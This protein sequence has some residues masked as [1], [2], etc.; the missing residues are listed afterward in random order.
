MDTYAVILCVRYCRDVVD[1][2]Q[3]SGPAHLD[4]FAVQLDSED[5]A[6]DMNDVNR[7]SSRDDDSII[8]SVIAR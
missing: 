1:T 2:G 6:R 8:R 7:R 3:L 5:D 4:H